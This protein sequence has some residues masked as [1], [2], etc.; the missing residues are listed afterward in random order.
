MCQVVVDNV[1]HRRCALIPTTNWA[2]GV[3]TLTVD[4]VVCCGRYLAPA[5]HHAGVR[6]VYPLARAAT[7]WGQLP[8]TTECGLGAAGHWPALLGPEHKRACAC[9]PLYAGVGV[10]VAHVVWGPC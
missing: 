7:K 3:A 10:A 1:L 6:V 4:D 9:V 8:P 2:V 5:A